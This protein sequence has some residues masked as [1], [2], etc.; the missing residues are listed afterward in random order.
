[1]ESSV[2]ESASTDS[3][4]QQLMA[5]ERLIGRIRHRQLALI[6][7]LDRRQTATA[8]GCTTMVEWVASRIDV[9][10]TTAAGL[11][12]TARRLTDQPSLADDLAA[13][14]VSFERT[15]LLAKLGGLPDDFAHLDLGNLRRLVARRRPITPVMERAVFEGRGINLQPSL[16]RSRCKVWGELTGLSGVTVEEAF[17]A[18]ADTFPQDARTDSRA[19]RHA[20]AP[21][22][23]TGFRTQVAQ[24]SAAAHS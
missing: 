12:G 16:D 8:D 24:L 7:E 20:D 21:D 11:V 1:M 15:E 19:A 18:K 4:E 23:D 3:I 17:F 9:T 5:D 22:L 6:D 10:R 13:G 14:H 2:L